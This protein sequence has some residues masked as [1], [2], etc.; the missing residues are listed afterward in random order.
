[1][2][3]QPHT[4]AWYDRLASLQ[5]GYHYPWKSRLGAWTGEAAYLALVREHLRPDADV[6]DVACGHGDVALDLAPHCRSILGYDRTTPW[7][8]LAQQTARKRGITNA[9]FVC[10]NS[11]PGANGGR[12][13][14]PATDTSFDLLLCRRGPHHWIADARRV[15][16]PGAV[17]LMLSPN[18]T[19]ATPWSATLPAPLGWADAD[20]PLWARERIGTLLAPSGLA[21]DSYWTFV[22]P[23]IFPNPGEMYRGRA[24]GY[25]TDEVPPFDEVCPLLERI[26]AEHGGPAGLA[27]PHSRFLWKA[28]VPR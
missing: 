25:S 3:P 12:A 22:V 26:F 14:I 10:Y 27:V 20:N 16:R 11:S 17:L 6:L 24:W 15:A 2:G 18:P 1:M 9:T 13:H 19:P 5:T 23:E 7:I 21:I 8:A 28:T 4:A